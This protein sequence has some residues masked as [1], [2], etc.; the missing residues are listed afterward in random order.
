MKRILAVFDGKTYAADTYAT[1][2]RRKYGFEVLPAMLSEN[3]VDEEHSCVADVLK[4]CREQGIKL[5]GILLHDSSLPADNSILQAEHRLWQRA[6][7]D[8]A[9]LDAEGDRYKPVVEALGDD[10]VEVSNRQ[11]HLENIVDNAHRRGIEK[12]R[13][14]LNDRL[15]NMEAMLLLNAPTDKGTQL[16]RELRDGPYKGVPIVVGMAFDEKRQAFMDAGATRVVTTLDSGTSDGVD[17]LV[18]EMG[19]PKHLPRGGDVGRQL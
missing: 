12:T 14:S 8:L 16:I 11:A 18:E 6:K 7:T 15:G 4:R 2:L 10:P 13:A 17:E 9:S 1:L 3:K 5:D 19:K